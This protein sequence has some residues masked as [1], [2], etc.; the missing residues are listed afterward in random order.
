MITLGINAAYHDCA[1]CLVRDG[2]V[3]AAAEEERFT[4]VK[5]GKRPVPFTVW[6][7]PYHAIDYCLREAGAT[8]CDVDHVAYSFEPR[9]LPGV[10][11]ADPAIA[12]PLEPSARGPA[13]DQISP[14]DPLFACY[15][16]NA[17]R[18]LAAGAPHHLRERFQGARH[19]GP[20]RWH[21][22]EHHL[23][24]EA[25]AFLASPFD[26][27]AVLTMDGRGERAT[28]SY[29]MFVNGEYQ[30]LRQINVPHSLGL[31]YEAV[32]QYLGFL[33]SSDEYK[34]YQLIWNRFLACQMPP[35]EF[36]QTSVTLAAKTKDGD[37]VF[38]ATGRKLV[39]D[40]FM[41]V[42]GI[43]SEDQLLLKVKGGHIGMMA[44]SGALKFTWPH[45][46]SWLAERSE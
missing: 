12:L 46:D 6:Q 33:H 42:A 21:Y 15:V 20:F 22:V 2:A 13:S 25:S 43:S 18:Q 7:L 1:A 8:L 32:T 10:R 24:H 11:S 26:A 34:V 41:K 37:A 17:P 40:G 3:V 35:A 4:H 31:V 29:G 44:G 39:F 36:D 16:I 45:I 38:R 14:W 23:A 28:T 9:L 27:G 30:R 5:H 19:D